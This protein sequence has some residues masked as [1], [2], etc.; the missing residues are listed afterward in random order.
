MWSIR[1]WQARAG[2]LRNA[3]SGGIAA[4]GGVQA[5]L[6]LRYLLLAL[7]PCLVLTGLTGWLLLRSRKAFVSCDG[8]K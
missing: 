6:V 8:I 1:P 3:G 5:G 4:G 7:L 2:L